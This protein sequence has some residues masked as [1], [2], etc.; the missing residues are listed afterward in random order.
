MALS[1]WRSA[2]TVRTRARSWSI[3][4]PRSRSAGTAPRIWP[5]S[6]PSRA[7]SVRSPP[8]RRCRD[9]SRPGPP[10]SMWRCRRFGPLGRRRGPGVAAAPAARRAARQPRRRPGD[11]GLGRQ[12]SAVAICLCGT[13]V[14]L[15]RSASRSGRE[16]SPPAGILARRWLSAA[17][18]TDC[19]ERVV[20]KNRSS[21]VRRQPRTADRFRP[22]RG[23][24]HRDSKATRWGASKPVGDAASWR[25]VRCYVAVGLLT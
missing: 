10:T 19:P 17:C 16:A 6:G 2:R 23:G 15:A 14:H 25:R 18:R 11:R 9:W 7:C 5:W 4:R 1:P 21:V 3:L 20:R 22:I 8:I 12:R 24:G 13:A